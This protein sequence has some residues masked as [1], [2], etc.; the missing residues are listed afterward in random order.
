[1]PAPYTTA[2]EV[3]TSLGE[4]TARAVYDYDNSG[5]VDSAPLAQDIAYATSKINSYLRRRYR[6]PIEGDVPEIIKS[7]A[8]DIVTAR[9]QL[10]APEVVRVDGEKMMKQA[11]ID[12]E[13]LRDDK[14]TLDIATLPASL[15]DR[16]LMRRGESATGERQP[17]MFA[18]GLGDFAKLCRFTFRSTAPTSGARSPTAK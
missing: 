11:T 12:L 3:V 10:R 7:I 14:T 5:T 16:V 17:A 13:S 4:A 2:D 9:A 6:L 8:R 1:M 15:N 18:D